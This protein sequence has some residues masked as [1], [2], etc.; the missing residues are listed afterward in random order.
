MRQHYKH[1]GKGQY[2]PIDAKYQLSSQ[3]RQKIV[4]EKFYRKPKP[5]CRKPFVTRDKHEL[6]AL[7]IVLQLENEAPSN[8]TILN[9]QL[10]KFLT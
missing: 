5:M 10:L 8:E 3:Q 6:T 7:E 9:S 1:Q 4:H 2:L